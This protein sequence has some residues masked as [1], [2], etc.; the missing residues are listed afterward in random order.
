MVNSINAERNNSSKDKDIIININYTTST[1]SVNEKQIEIINKIKITDRGIGFNK[2]QINSFKSINS[3]TNQALGC[4]GSGKFEILRAF[5]KIK[6]Q[7]FNNEGIIELELC[8]KNYNN[9]N[10]EGFSKETYK[11]SSLD[12]T[13]VECIYDE[14][15]QNVGFDEVKY[16]KSVDLENLKDRIQSKLLL[17][18]ALLSKEGYN[19]NIK[20]QDCDFLQNKD[21]IGL[22]S[23]SE[24]FKVNGLE[25][26]FTIYHL[27][28][29]KI[30]PKANES[31]NCILW[32][33]D[34]I[35]VKKGVDFF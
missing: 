16:I 10:I 30:T 27:R 20:L 19:I 24:I 15:L 5:H 21:L 8:E 22:D 9:N 3:T 25:D 12:I 32:V 34:N 17:K 33:S 4:R 31:R 29:D 13:T 11:Y 18:L 6:V 7:S 26:E 1:I 28:T 35:E 2:E 23:N 14:E